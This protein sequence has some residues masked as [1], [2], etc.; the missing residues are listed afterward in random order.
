[1]GGRGVTEDNVWVGIRTIIL[2]RGA[3]ETVET[4]WP[5]VLI[6]GNMLLSL[7]GFFKTQI[8]FC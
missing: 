1:M 6:I 5:G 7:P 3:I 2:S 4:V 8:T